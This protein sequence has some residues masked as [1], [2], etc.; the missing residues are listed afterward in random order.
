M[1][2]IQSLLQLGWTVAALP[3]ITFHWPYGSASPPERLCPPTAHTQRAGPVHAPQSAGHVTA[4][5]ICLIGLRLRLSAQAALLPT[6][7]AC[8]PRISHRAPVM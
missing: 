5:V 1:M 2:E 6:A 3:I 8:R 7:P 4:D